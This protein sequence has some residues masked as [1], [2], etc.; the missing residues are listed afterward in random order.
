M[1][2]D[3]IKEKKLKGNAKAK[4]KNALKISLEQLENSICKIYYEGGS[5]TGFFL[6]IIN[7]N[8]WNSLF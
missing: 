3:Y 4:S 1:S 5:G 8:E 2:D 6:N 7:M